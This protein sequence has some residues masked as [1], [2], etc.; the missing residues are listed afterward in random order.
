MAEVR[1]V[2]VEDDG[3][4]GGDPGTGQDQIELIRI[5][6]GVVRMAQ[7]LVRVPEHRA[8][9]VTLVVAGAAHVHLDYADVGIVQMRRDPI[10]VDQHT[11]LHHSSIPPG[12]SPVLRARLT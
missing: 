8:G 10:R 2:A 4:L 6:R 11:L 12:L 3:H 5:D 9:N 7:V 1:A